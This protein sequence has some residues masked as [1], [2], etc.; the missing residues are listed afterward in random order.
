MSFV[1]IGETRIKKSNIKNYGISIEDKKG[2]FIV[3]EPSGV[4]EALMYL[5]NPKPF[6]E[7]VRVKYLYVTTFQ[8]D[9]YK[10][11]EDE[12]DIQSIIE[13]LDAEKS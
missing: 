1:K 2:E 8:G 7:Q 10:F 5:W 9:N 3:T 11:Y 13:I 4:I 12:V 6:K